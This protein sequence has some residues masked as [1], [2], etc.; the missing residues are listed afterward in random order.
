MAQAEL[1]A[2]RLAAGQFAQLGDELHQL[3]RRGEGA[4]ARRRNAILTHRHATGGGD[5]GGDLVLG[6]DTAVSRLGALAE[7]DLDHL[8]LRVEGLGGEALRVEL[9]IAGAAPEV[10][11]AQFPDQV[12]AVLA[13]IGTDAALAGVVVEVA[14]L[15][16]TVQRANGVGAEGA[17]THRRDVEQRSGVRLAALWP[18]DVDAEL[19]GIAE[20]RRTHR[21]ADEF[22]AGGV[23]VDQG[24]EG[25]L[26]AF[27]LRPRVDQRALGAGEGQGVAVGFQQVLAD[28]RA[29][30]FHQIADVA[31]DRIVAAHRVWRLGQVEQA[32]QAQGHAQEGE[33]PEPFG[34]AEERQ[35]EQGEQGDTGEKRIA[36]E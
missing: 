6:Q 14:H 7:L 8:H 2:D 28:L 31:Q 17:E 24:A 3:D 9:A 35:A 19:A 4:V 12:A 20:W 33:R 29:D 25:L 10:A 18:A 21:V 26:R 15:R 36:T 16:A 11:A 30:A 13:V 5:L 27:V 1:E 34:A 23:H 32:E 22:V